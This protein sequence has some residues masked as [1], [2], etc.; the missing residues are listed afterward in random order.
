MPRRNKNRR[1]NNRQKRSNRRQRQNRSRAVAPRPGRT[2]PIRTPSNF[3]VRAA[4]NL[5]GALPGGTVLA[6]IADFTWRVIAATSALS[7]SPVMNTNV[8]GLNTCFYLNAAACIRESPSLTRSNAIVYTNFRDSQLISLTITVEPINK[9]QYR[10]GS[11]ALMFTPFR[12]AGDETAYGKEFIMPTFSKVMS[13]QGVVSGRMDQPLTLTYR[14]TVRDGFVGLYIPIGTNFGMVCV[15]YQ[16]ENRIGYTDFT[17]DEFCARV[18]TNAV[19]NL[20]TGTAAS[21][22][23]SVSTK[24]PEMTKITNVAT[25]IFGDG[26]EETMVYKSATAEKNSVKYHGLERAGAAL[27][28]C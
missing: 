7:A 11:W 10:S 23:A 20:R 15:V 18:R 16:E 24:I 5:L 2:G 19:V 6:N 25:I 3:I 28:E 4:R 17:A 9:L 12:T 1:R 13:H 21:E 27:M 14:P 8:I 22:A 26:H